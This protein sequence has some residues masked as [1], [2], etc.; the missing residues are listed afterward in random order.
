M[1]KCQ[2]AWEGWPA[3]TG[4]TKIFCATV[5]CE[6]VCPVIL[7]FLL[8]MQESRVPPY[9]RAGFP[10]ELPCVTKDAIDIAAFLQVYVPMFLPSQ[11]SGHPRLNL[12]AAV[13]DILM[14]ALL[15]FVRTAQHR[16]CWLIWFCK[17]FFPFYPS[18]VTLHHHPVIGSFCM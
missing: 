2:L 16:K 14:I 5:A 4:R 3:S 6:V 7:L 18:N 17:F 15:L 10:W 9:L 13:L 11:R 12:L 8:I 1:L